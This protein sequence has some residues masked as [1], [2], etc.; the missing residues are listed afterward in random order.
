[1]YEKSSFMQ[2]L[3]DS[4]AVLLVI[5][6]LLPMILHIVWGGGVVEVIVISLWIPSSAISMI[7][8]W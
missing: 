2:Q 5:G 1:M 7:L 8:S 6:V 3:L 4:P